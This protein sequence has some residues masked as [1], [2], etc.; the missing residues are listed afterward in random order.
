MP[1]DEISGL[2]DK[3]AEHGEELA[4]LREWKT[5]VSIRI[6]TFVTKTE[7]TVVK[8]LVYS[9]AGTTLTSVL[10][11]LLAKVIVK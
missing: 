9:L 1:A 8:I 5:G 7:F 6:D 10:A 2:R 11:A 4:A 3:V